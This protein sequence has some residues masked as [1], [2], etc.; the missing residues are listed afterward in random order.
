MSAG[1][2]PTLIGVVAGLQSQ[3]LPSAIA[4]LEICGVREVGLRETDATRLT[5]GGPNQPH[6][7]FARPLNGPCPPSRPAQILPR[8][9]YCYTSPS[10][11][12]CHLYNRFLPDGRVVPMADKQFAGRSNAPIKIYKPGAGR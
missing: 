8:A 2:A 6:F 9:G 10:S 3:T 5:D 12:L 7:P 4:A 11:A 1:H